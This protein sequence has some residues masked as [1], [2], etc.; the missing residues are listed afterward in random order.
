E[1]LEKGGHRPHEVRPIVWVPFAILSVATVGI[2]LVGFAFGAELQHMF[3]DYLAKYFGITQQKQVQLLQN[4]VTTSHLIQPH[5]QPKL[6]L[7]LNP[8]AALASIGAFAVGG[9]L[10]YMFY[11]ARKI[12]PEIISKNILTRRIWTFLYNR[13]YLKSA[14]YWGTV[15]GPVAVYR[16]T[17]RYFEF[18]VIEGI[19]HAVEFSMTS[20]SRVIKAGQTGIT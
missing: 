17:W 14:I 3:T 19:S 11:I 10:G 16:I 12:D 20:F 6:F 13:W 2:G 5:A 15:I 18:T 9:F 8:V 7:G 1:Q 4:P